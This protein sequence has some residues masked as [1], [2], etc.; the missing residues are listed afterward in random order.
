[1]KKKFYLKI[2]I[3]SFLPIA[4]LC[5]CSSNDKTKPIVE[6][7]VYKL[8]TKALNKLKT[9]EYEQATK[10]FDEVERQHP[11]SKWA[12]RAQLMSAYAYYKK[13]SYDDAI[14]TLDR[15]IQLHPG[16]KDIAY[17]YYM[18]AL[19]YYEQIS[20]VRRDQ[21]ITKLAMDGLE[22]VVTRFPNTQYATDAR[23]KLDLTKDHLAGKEMA[24][25]RYYH[26]KKQFLAS[27]NRFKEVVKNY[28][29]TTHVPEALY[30]LVEAYTAL[31]LTKEAK[32]TASVLGYNFPGNK[33]YQKAYELHEK[34]QTLEATKKQ[35]KK[36]LGW[37]Y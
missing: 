1:M 19:C 17:A 21:K 13:S 16:N 8:Y 35:N 34:G 15:F 23:L 28:Q 11:Y 37:A 7:P 3:L 12:T 33:W 14:L 26:K 25:G 36:W 9:R 32:K 29:T 22:E 2:F 18:R 31:G 27:I 24:I 6:K 30:R 4:L 10:A 5:A 20:D